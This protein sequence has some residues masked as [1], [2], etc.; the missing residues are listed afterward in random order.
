M[1][2][3]S[4]MKNCRTVTNNTI[5]VCNFFSIN[6]SQHMCKS[7]HVLPYILYIRKK[8]TSCQ[9]TQNKKQ[10]ERIDVTIEIKL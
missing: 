10:I 3:K 6:A 7:K 8:K 4:E 1:K 2:E 5:F 9:Y